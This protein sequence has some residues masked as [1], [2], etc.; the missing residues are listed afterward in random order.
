M[1]QAKPRSANTLP[2]KVRAKTAQRTYLIGA[3]HKAVDASALAAPTEIGID[4][5][6]TAEIIGLITDTDC[7]ADDV[8]KALEANRRED[9]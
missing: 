2:T 6:L 8:R 4:R 5:Q 9:S 3:F 7:S 1:A